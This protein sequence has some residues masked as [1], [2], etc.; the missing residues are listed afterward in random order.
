MNEPPK[1]GSTQDPLC[2]ICHKP[3][4]EHSYQEQQKC[5]E[6]I[7]ESEQYF[8]PIFKIGFFTIM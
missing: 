2:K 3:L 6:K 5:A 8:Q 4:R 7:R 1:P